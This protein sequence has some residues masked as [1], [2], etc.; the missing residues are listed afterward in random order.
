MVSP[1]PGFTLKR[2]AV[3]LE[4]EHP[5]G[6]LADID[7]L[8]ETGTI[9]SRADLGLAPRRCFLCDEAAMLCRQ[10]NSH[11]QEQLMA[12]IATMLTGALSSPTWPKGY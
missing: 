4:R 3:R 10:R 7:V 8:T 5:L 2:M 1:L 9:I 11:P 12:C 6:R